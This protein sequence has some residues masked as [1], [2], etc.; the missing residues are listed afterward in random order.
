MGMNQEIK[1]EWVADLISGEIHKTKNQLRRGNRMCALGVLCNI[2]AKHHPSIAVQQKNKSKYLGEGQA[3]PKE[4]AIWAFGSK[5]NDGGP[6]LK[7]K[8]YKHTVAYLNDIDG[9]TF[10]QIAKLIDEQL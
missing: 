10:K 4:V 9:L 5:C 8:G 2:H 7:H 6:K 1:K 3:L